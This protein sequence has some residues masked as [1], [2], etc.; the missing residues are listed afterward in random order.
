MVISM[1]NTLKLISTLVK[2]TSKKELTE[3]EKETLITTI[4]E[5]RAGGF[6]SWELEIL[7]DGRLSSSTIRAK[8]KNVTK[9]GKFH[10]EASL[11]FLREVTA[12]TENLDEFEYALQLLRF[13]KENKITLKDL[14]FMLKTLKD[15]DIRIQDVVKLLRITKN[16]DELS[17]VQAIVETMSSKKIPFT[18][19][20]IIL[21]ALQEY[22]ASTLIEIIKNKETLAKVE[23][24][25]RNLRE[26]HENLN[27]EYQ[28]L[29]EATKKLQKTYIE[30]QTQYKHLIESISVLDSLMHEKGLSP[31]TIE[32]LGKILE[33]I[34][35]NEL[36]TISTSIQAKR[37]LE[38]DIR[39]LE[40]EKRSLEDQLEE[41]KIQIENLK[42]ENLSLWK[43]L[44]ENIQESINHYNELIKN[45][46]N[47]INNYYKALEQYTLTLEFAKMLYSLRYSND[48]EE[49]RNIPLDIDVLLINAIINHISAIGI[50]T[51]VSAHTLELD[52]LEKI[53][54]YKLST[55][56]KM[57]RWGLLSISSSDNRE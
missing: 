30:M 26:T 29:Q 15:N 19:I 16:P 13:L 41:L 55:I 31:L 56:L 40:R 2:I 5:L 1:D 17:H 27:K 4:K 32:Q 8:T 48:E 10:K 12:L 24:D 35:P 11:K 50:D 57:A 54:T 34:D 21:N 47:I 25:L 37:E 49:L 18:D 9:K 53:G 20:E 36:M 14:L 33:I 46:F 6:K 43:E 28:K 51:Y 22:K 52:K 39:K 7:I 42:Q 23:R 38:R 44:G 3:K 45:S